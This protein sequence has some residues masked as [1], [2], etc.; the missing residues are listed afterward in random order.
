MTIITTHHQ[1]FAWQ[2]RAGIHAKGYLFDGVGTFRRGEKLLDY[3]VTVTD[4]DSFCSKLRE[5]NGCFAVI[6]ETDSQLLAGVDPVRSIPLFHAVKND[7]C[8]L[9]DDVYAIQQELGGAVEIDP[10]SRE[11]FLRVG[12]TVGPCTLDPRVG[13][14]EAGEFYV[15][16]KPTGLGSARQYFSH[17]HGNYTDKSED[18]L[19]EELD[20]VTSRWARRL[21]DSVGGR[22]IVIP[23]SGGYDSRSIA[24]ALKRERY[25]NVICYSYGSPTSFEWPVARD[26][27]SRLG[28]P[29]HIVE[30]NRRNWQTTIESPRFVEY[31]RFASQRCAV[32]HIQDLAAYDMLVTQKVLPDGA[33][34]VPGFCGDLL[35]G[36]FVP[37][38]VLF[39][40]PKTVLAEGINKYLYRTL[41]DLRNARITRKMRLAIL[42]RIGEYTSR[43]PSDDIQAF[44]SIV[45][46]WFTRHKVAKYVVNAVRVYE[47]CGNEW[48]LPLWD[49]ELIEWWY[50]VPLT[51]RSNSVLYHRYLFERLFDPMNVSLRRRPGKQQVCLGHLADRWLPAAFI[52]PVRSIYRLLMKPKPADICSFDDA[53]L[54]LVQQCHRQWNPGDFGHIG[55]VMAAWCDDVLIGNST[56][57]PEE[58]Q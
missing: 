8:V 47:Y 38:E 2:C 24:C 19:V 42:R 53:S 11:E 23:L 13:Q 20:Q 43:F 45:E 31:C 44:C 28:Y 56:R 17:A 25:N 22:T 3:F 29:I 49:N 50:Q 41:F 5:A 4:A 12:Y 33:V 6:V 1:G 46:D 30:Y 39:G 9:G 34:V 27:A 55:G 32:P 14:I 40:R 15:W 48:R 57:T 21:I 16:D 18:V 26:V 37:V 52:P 7:S 35:G 58:A 36:S 10:V 51:L 54:L